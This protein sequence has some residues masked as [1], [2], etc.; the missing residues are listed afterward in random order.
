MNDA[1]LAVLTG[2]PPV[3]AVIAIGY[4]VRVSGL[5]PDS[6]WSGINQLS[7][8]VLLPAILFVTLAKADFGA[9]GL[10]AT[11]LAALAGGLAAALIGALATLGAGLKRAETAAL[12]IVAAGWNLFFFLALAESVFGPALRPQATVILAAGAVT[13]PVLVTLAAA[14]GARRSAPAAL[15]RSPVLLGALAGLAVAPMDLQTAAPWLLAPVEILA[16]GA[17]GLILLA[18]GGGLRLAVLKGRFAVL[19]RAALARSLISPAAFIAIGWAFGL[20]GEALG[21]I[22][23][24]GGAPGAAF[25]YAL[26]RENEGPAELAAGM[27]T[28][29]VLAS[30]LV[31]PGFTLLAHSL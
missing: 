29:S 31:L 11:A 21:L 22:A 18:I 2:F 26:I 5:L 27:I 9:P 3:F 28:A 17:L 6:A 7:Y 12:I 10:T 24:A 19:L 20:R 13:I 4:A 25:L 1:S 14:W 8:R 15:M 16:A 23:L 30:A